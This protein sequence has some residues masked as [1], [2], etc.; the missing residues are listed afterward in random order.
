VVTAS[1]AFLADSSI[2]A[3]LPILSIILDHAVEEKLLI[4][5]PM[6]GGGALWRAEQPTEDIDPFTPD[7]LKRII[8]S[9]YEVDSDFGCLVQIV[10]QCGLRPGEGLALRRC[11]IDLE[12]AEIHVRKTFSRSRMGPTKTKSSTRT[13]S[14][15]DHVLVD[16]ALSRSIIGR[17]KN[18]KVTNMDP[19][20]R[21]FPLSA[22]QYWPRRWTLALTKAGVR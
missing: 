6:R 17:L 4:Q 11:D 1:R 2:K 22:V 7:E 21:M 12:R 3:A 20:S 15:V 19:E 14:L 13:V 10:A 18:M 16:E 9:A 8:H 5:N